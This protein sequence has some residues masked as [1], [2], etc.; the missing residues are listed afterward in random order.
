MAEYSPED[1]AYATRIVERL[2]NREGKGLELEQNLVVSDVESDA[3]TFSDELSLLEEFDANV[4]AVQ[5][6]GETV[7]ISL[8]T[9]LG[10]SEKWPLSP[11]G[12]GKGR[13]WRGHPFFHEAMYDYLRPILGREGKL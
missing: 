13:R 1:A 9:A 3:N 12:I 10:G 5:I 7:P 6:A 8:A 4:P 11:F 2:V